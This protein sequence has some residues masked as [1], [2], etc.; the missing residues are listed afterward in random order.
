[1]PKGHITNTKT[2]KE[3]RDRHS[4]PPT[5]LVDRD[6]DTTFCVQEGRRGDQDAG[7]L[8]A[9]NG[10]WAVRGAIP[11]DEPSR[12]PFTG[13]GSR[14]LYWA[15]KSAFR[16]GSVL[17]DEWDDVNV[18]LNSFATGTN[19]RASA[20]SSHAEG[21][22]TLARGDSSHV[23]GA[24]T[25]A[26]G[27]FS[28]CEGQLTIA[29]GLASHC[30]GR[31]SQATGLASHSEGSNC[32][33]TG[34]SSHAEGDVTVAS[35]P[36]SHAE[37]SATT[38]SGRASHA[39]GNQ[40]V[41]S[42][43]LSHAEGTGSVA[44]GP[45]S[46]AEGYATVALGDSSHAEGF[47]ALALGEISHAEGAFTR[48]SGR[49]SHTE[50]FR[51]VADGT[52]SHVGGANSV[53]DGFFSFA[54]GSFVRANGVMGVV[55]VGE[56]GYARSDSSGVNN[57]SIQ[58]AGGGTSTVSPGAG[59]DGIGLI[60]RTT[61]P[62][63]NP[64]AEGVA[65]RWIGGGA[66]FAEYFEW[67]DGNPHREDRYGYFVAVDSRSTKGTIVHATR[68]KDVI[69]VTSARSAFVGDSA[70]VGWQGAVERD[71]LLRPVT[72]LSYRASLV[73]ELRIIGGE[74]SVSEKIVSLDEQGAQI[75][76]TLSESVDATRAKVEEALAV[77]ATSPVLPSLEPA[78]SAESAESQIEA[79]IRDLDTAKDDADLLKSVADHFEDNAIRERI[80]ALDPSEVMVTSPA[81]KVG[82][83]YV[84]RSQRPEWIPVGLIGK[85]VVRDDG[86]LRAGQTCK[87]RRGIAVPGD[88]WR[89][90]RRVSPDSV[91]ILYK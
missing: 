72:R 17:G 12:M 26:D 65:D 71:P 44:S 13:P 43:E 36:N 55:I 88:R 45:Q 51:T 41:A 18:G 2:D 23:E 87:C 21:R 1:M 37:G 30:E 7:I 29:S 79:I 74:L 50:G 89:V 3:C 28:H 49:F 83:P 31:T 58:L 40:T 48:A 10:L 4:R 90:L 91:L 20:P 52:V 67:S 64:V 8:R 76:Q 86:T 27:A 84:P 16:V 54:H 81:F 68:S 19:T 33:A 62:G 80:L 66:D 9:Q 78:G 77:D 22:D 85:V 42:G 69:G 57:F 11:D 75:R 25:T 5:C 70:E 15:P 24:G 47:R 46:H 39:E 73:R 32:N 56:N 53:A 60:L 82:E 6:G 14:M 34:P 59:T 38:A 35:G 61:V 63:L